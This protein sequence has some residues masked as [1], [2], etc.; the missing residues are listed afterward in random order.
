MNLDWWNKGRGKKTKMRRWKAQLPVDQWRKWRKKTSH[1]IGRWFAK[2]LKAEAWKTDHPIREQLQEC[3]WRERT[4]RCDVSIGTN[5]RRRSLLHNPSSHA[6]SRNDERRSVIHFRFV[7]SVHSIR[8]ISLL[9]IYS[10]FVLAFF[11]SF[12][13]Y[14]SE[15]VNPLFFFGFPLSKL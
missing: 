4:Q 11:F 6:Y 8:N 12:F 10:N 15:F 5:Q 13:L 7:A 2:H 3:Q 1:K 9:A 14:I